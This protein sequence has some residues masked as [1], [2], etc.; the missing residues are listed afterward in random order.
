MTSNQNNRRHINRM[1]RKLSTLCLIVALGGLLQAADVKLDPTGTWKWHVTNP[2]GQS[3]EITIIFKLQG[4]ALTGAVI[5]SS[6]T[7][8]ITNGVLKGDQVSFQ[9]IRAARNG[10]STTTYTGKFSGDTIKGRVEIDA[11]G[12]KLSADWEIKRETAKSKD[13]ASK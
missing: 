10:K 11:S 2:D 3:H 6:G 5:K 9:T 1:K 8:A 13:G 7:T 12:K 4:Q